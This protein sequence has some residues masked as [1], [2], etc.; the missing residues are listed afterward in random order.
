MIGTEVKL[1]TLMNNKVLVRHGGGYEKLTTILKRAAY[2]EL[3]KL[4]KRMDD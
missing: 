4:L 1:V 2:P 3:R